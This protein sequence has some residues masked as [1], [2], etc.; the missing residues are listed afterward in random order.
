M[1][2]SFIFLWETTTE[3]DAFI[4]PSGYNVYNIVKIL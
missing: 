4:P 3:R 1:V 2:M